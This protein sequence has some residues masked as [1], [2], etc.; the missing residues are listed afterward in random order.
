MY[1]SAFSRFPRVPGFSR[2][3]TTE[4]PSHVRDGS[5]PPCLPPR[6][7]KV[8]SSGPREA[9]AA[10]RLS[11][12]RELYVS[13]LRLR[14]AREGATTRAVANHAG[15]FDTTIIVAIHA[16]FCTFRRCLAR[17]RARRDLHLTRLYTDTVRHV[18]RAT[19]IDPSF[20]FFYKHHFDLSRY[21]CMCANACSSCIR[22]TEWRPAPLVK[23]LRTKNVITIVVS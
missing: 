22:L 15:T 7:A 11:G 4:S 10:F 19:K 6:S 14:G 12:E 13:F 16:G 17:S 8:V 2:G 23:T 1:R 21:A 5:G 3:K 9:A 20:F 18:T